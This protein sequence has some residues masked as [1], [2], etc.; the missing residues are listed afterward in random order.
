[1]L[2]LTSLFVFLVAG[3]NALPDGTHHALQKR[4]TDF[5]R[6]PDLPLD[7]LNRL[8]EL[9]AFRH[10][11]CEKCIP[12]CWKWQTTLKDPQAGCE[13]YCTTQWH[14]GGIGAWY[15]YSDL[16]LRAT[17]FSRQYDSCSNDDVHKPRVYDTRG[18][19]AARAARL[20]RERREKTLVDEDDEEFEALPTAED[21][22]WQA[23]NRQEAQDRRAMEK[24]AETQNRQARI[25]SRPTRNGVDPQQ[26]VSQMSE[27]GKTVLDAAKAAPGQLKSVKVPPM[28]GFP[29]PKTVP[30]LPAVVR[31]V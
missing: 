3:I 6:W 12:H 1:M 21:A 22:Y 25:K 13:G 9:E 8:K 29:I 19:R 2:L 17:A 28:I 14:W 7:L 20:A 23:L 27:A 15:R 10:N 5:S 24:A 16:N 18:Q 26:L 31:P 11:F 4:V 30:G